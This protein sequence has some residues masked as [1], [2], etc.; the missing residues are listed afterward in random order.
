[1]RIVRGPQEVTLTEERD[2]RHRDVVVLERRVDLPLEEL[3]RLRDERA[4]AFVG[5]ELLG[6]PEPPVAPVELLDEPRQPSGAG[7]GHHHAQLRVPLENAPGEEVDEGLEEVRE[8]ELGVLEDARGLAG[9]AIARLADE[10]RDVPRENDAAPLE[11]LPER[12]PRRVVQLGVDVG[13]HQID[14]AHAAFRDDAFELGERGLGGLR[15]HRKADEPIRRRLAEIEQPVVVDAVAGAAQDGI[16]GRDLEDRSEDHLGLDA[17]AVHVGETQLRDDRAARALVVDGGTVEGVVERLDRT[18][19]TGRGRLAVPAAPDLAVTD[20]HRLSVP[21]LDVRRAVEQRSRQPRRP[22]IL[23]QLAEV[24]VIVAGDEPVSHMIL[25][26]YFFAADISRIPR[27]ASA[28]PAIP[29]PATT[30]WLT[31]AV[32]DAGPRRIGFAM[33]TSMAANF[34]CATAATSAG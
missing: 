10:H 34:T 20:P 3:A 28:Y 13:D 4:A 11:R 1:M 27:S 33:C 12:L 31:A 26:P 19:R 24:H 9:G 21:V 5:P 14:L 18:R 25:P 16:V 15:Q 32:C 2:E 6:L 7:L 17:V 8:E 30:P 29:K 23:G 22:Q